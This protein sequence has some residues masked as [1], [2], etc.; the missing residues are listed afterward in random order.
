MEGQQ[1]ANLQEAGGAGQQGHRSGLLLLTP[2]ISGL[3][4]PSGGC[5]LLSLVQGTEVPPSLGVCG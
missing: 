4:N 5:T 3:D 2:L 1:V